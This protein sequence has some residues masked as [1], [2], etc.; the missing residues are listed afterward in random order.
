MNKKKLIIFIIILI[1]II[2]III[3]F[4]KNTAKTF[5]IGNNM[6]SQE[7]VDYILNINS[8][9]AKV[10]VDVKSNKNSNKY[11]IKQQYVNPDV[12]TQEV[13]EP[14]NITGVKMIKNEQGLKLENTNLNLST[15]FENYN[16]ITDNCLDLNAFIDDY[17]N[18]SESKFEEKDNQ[19]IMKTKSKNDNKYKQYKKLYIDKSTHNPIKMEIDDYNQN[20][21]VYISYNEVKINSIDKKDVLAFKLYDLADQI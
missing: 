19:L 7:I 20:T 17:K 15:I 21:L 10:T 5:K 9:E 6:S 12:L 16:F 3:Y 4:C 1:L 13:L 11:V 2:G 14:S 8:Y 18:S